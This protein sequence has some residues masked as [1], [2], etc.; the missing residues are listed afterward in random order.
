VTTHSVLCSMFKPGDQSLNGSVTVRLSLF[1]YPHIQYNGSRLFFS[2]APLVNLTLSP[3]SK[4]WHHV[5][6]NALMPLQVHSNS[7]F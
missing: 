3:V 6:C 5:E 2:L 1:D 4:W 7:M